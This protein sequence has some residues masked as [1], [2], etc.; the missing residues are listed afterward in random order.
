MSRAFYGALIGAALLAGISVNAFA[1]GPAGYTDCATYETGALTANTAP[2]QS[3]ELVQGM[4][5]GLTNYAL[6]IATAEEIR[7]APVDDVPISIVGAQQ[8]LVSFCNRNPKDNMTQ[9]GLALYRSL[10]P[11]LQ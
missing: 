10:Y 9:A 3:K 6:G 5:D 2:P 1:V 8:W 7:H 4:V 11:W